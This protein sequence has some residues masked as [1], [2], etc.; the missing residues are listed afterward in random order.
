MNGTSEAQRPAIVCV[1]DEAG[2]L[3]AIRRS[4]RHENVEVLT[5]SS[6][7]QALTLLDERPIA[8]VLT[9]YRMPDMNG[10]ELLEQVAQRSPETFRIVLTGYA[11]AHVLIDAVNRGQIYK[12]LYKPFQEE[13]IKLTVRAALEHYAQA[14]QNRA[15]LQELESKNNELATCNSLLRDGLEG[16][17]TQLALSFHALS[18]AQQ[19]LNEIPAAVVG[20]EPTCEISFA[21]R[22]ATAWFGSSAVASLV[23]AALPDLVPEPIL[24]CVQQVQRGTC[25]EQ[26]SETSREGV[27]LSVVCRPMATLPVSSRSERPVF[28][29]AVEIKE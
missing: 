21:N 27:R 20:I 29:F 6:G 11:E 2:I 12:I 13:D 8:L 18:L 4:L 5:A 28:L 25:D 23:G 16:T 26:W 22:L 3:R 24:K 14:C 19:L 10:I 9:D 15:L 7:P 17:K 1:D